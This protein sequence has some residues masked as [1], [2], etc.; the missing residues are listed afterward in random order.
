MAH[1]YGAPPDLVPKSA[2]CTEILAK[3][4]Y[5]IVVLIIVA[6]FAVTCGYTIKNWRINNEMNE[7]LDILT[8]LLDMG[9]NDTDPMMFARSV[10]E[11]EVDGDVRARDVLCNPKYGKPSKYCDSPTI[12]QTIG[13][14]S[15]DSDAFGNQLDV[16]AFLPLSRDVHE[17]T[18]GNL[19]YF[20]NQTLVESVEA[21]I[22][23]IADVTD[24][25]NVAVGL[26]SPP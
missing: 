25:T 26:L 8:A 21:K 6:A 23:S 14:L 19:V 17:L 7:K 20:I 16:D 9:D 12:G 3:I 11:I 13:K 5:G 22:V 18:I 10:E 4:V 2:T 15:V 24:A 1:T